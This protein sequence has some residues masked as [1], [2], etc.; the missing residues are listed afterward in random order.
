MKSKLK[1]F[2]LAVIG[3][4]CA[5][6]FTSCNDDDDNGDDPAVTGEVIDLGDGSDNYEIA[7]D[8]TL[9]YPNTYNLKGFVYVP[10]GKTITIEPGVV[11]KGDKASKG[12][13]IIER[14]GKI[15]AKGE[16]DR[17]IVFTSSQAPGS[18]KPGDWGGLIILG[19]AKN[20]AGEQ[21]IEG[22]VRS[23]HGGNDDADNSGVLSYVRVEFAGIEYSTDNDDQRYYF[24]IGRSRYSSRPSSGVLF[25]R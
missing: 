4:V 19:K 13:L 23:K 20:N 8:L 11:I 7:G 14:G 9:T 24:R 17:P 22:G 16:Q 21:T 25:R 5:A 3:A 18:R 2:V 12:T 10:D 1:F 6:G 15:M